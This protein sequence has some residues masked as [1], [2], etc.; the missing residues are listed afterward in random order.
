MA[1][2]RDESFDSGMFQSKFIHC[3]ITFICTRTLITI[4][5]CRLDFFV[6]MDVNEEIL[7]EA[8]GTYLIFHFMCDKKMTVPYLY[9]YHKRFQTY[10]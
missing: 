9:L 10:Q 7:N 1:E 5:S 4:D 2:G 6:D 8:N 3:C